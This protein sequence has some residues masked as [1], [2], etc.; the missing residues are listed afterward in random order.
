MKI[1]KLLPFLAAG[2]ALSI[3]ATSCGRSEHRAHGTN[4]MEDAGLLAIYERDGY[5]EVFIV[6]TAGEEVAHY[7]LLDR[8]DTTRRELPEGAVVLRV[9]LQ[10]GIIDSEVYASAFEELEATERIVGM[11]DTDYVTST[12]LKESIG[13]GEIADAGQSVSPNREK[14]LAMQPDAVLVSYYDGM[15]MQDL[16]RLGIPVIKMYDLQEATPLGRAEWLRLIGRITGTEAAADSIFTAVKEQYEST[17]RASAAQSHH[18][19]KIL[20]ETIY[21]GVWN[22]AGGDSYQA[23]MLK[24]AGGNYFKGADNSANTLRLSP[25]QVIGEGGDADIWLIRFYGDGDRLKATLDSDPLYHDIKAYREGRIY[26]SNTAESGLYREFPFHP[27]RLL[28]DYVV[29]FSGDT[30]T[31]LRYFRPLKIQD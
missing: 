18:S 5:D 20:T 23:R 25:E 28:R 13:R 29:I 21:E 14:I 10:K 22:V 1:F 3:A 31:P 16:D 6:N 30:I 12:F 9:P 7:V 4:L 17:R 27:E 19:P 15:Q 26:Y 2:V 24:D 8:G 11:F